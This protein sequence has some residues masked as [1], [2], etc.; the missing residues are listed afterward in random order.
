M[1]IYAITFCDF[2]GIVPHN[3]STFSKDKLTVYVTTSEVVVK[4]VSFIFT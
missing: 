1:I 4:T 2:K 3:Y